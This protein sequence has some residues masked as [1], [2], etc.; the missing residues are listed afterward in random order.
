MLFAVHL[1]LGSNRQKHHRKLYERLSAGE[2]GVDL[3]R[4]KSRQFARVR[5][6]DLTGLALVDQAEY[7]MSN[8]TGLDV[9]VYR[10]VMTGI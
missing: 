8:D 10:S 3:M 7:A 4:E 6:P 2:L 1:R 5:I 9:Y